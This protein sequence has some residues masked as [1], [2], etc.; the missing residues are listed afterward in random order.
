MGSNPS[1][2]ADAEDSDAK[3][4][5]RRKGKRDSKESGKN[6]NRILP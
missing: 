3:G 4:C 5:T 6:A 2:D 1:E